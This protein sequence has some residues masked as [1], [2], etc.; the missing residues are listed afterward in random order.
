MNSQDNTG[1]N[2]DEEYWQAI[3]SQGE[4]PIERPEA[5]GLELWEGFPN[6]LGDALTSDK[7]VHG[8]PD[9]GFDNRWVEAQEC[10][11]TDE[12]LELEATGYNRGGL[13]VEWHGLR[14]FV[15]A[16]HLSDFAPYQ[17]EE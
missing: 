17:G 14:G 9:D 6:G 5:D 3:L 11:E 4:T 1:P 13:L 2:L 15:P 8:R 7:V 12:I 16:S 10:F